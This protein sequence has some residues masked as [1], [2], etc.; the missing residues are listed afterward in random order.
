MRTWPANSSQGRPA[1]GVVSL[2]Q[3]R[4]GAGPLVAQHVLRVVQPRAGEPLRARHRAAAQ[5]P[6]GRRRRRDPEVIPDRLP[7]AFEIGH[8]PAPQVVVAVEVQAALAAEPA[9][10]RGQVR[11][12]HLFGAGCPQQVAVGYVGVLLSPA[13]AF[14]PEGNRASLPAVLTIF[15]YHFPMPR[16]RL[17]PSPVQALILRGHCHT[18]ALYGILPSAQSWWRPGRVSAGLGGAVP[19]AVGGAARARVAGWGRVV[20]QQQALRDCAQAMANYFHGSHCKPSWRKAGR[21]EG[22]RIV[23]LRPGQVRRLNRH[24][25]Q[26]SSPRRAGCGSLVSG[27][28]EARSFRVKLDRGRWHVAF[29]AVPAPIG[30]PVTAGGWRSRSARRC[31]RARCSPARA[32]GPPAAAQTAPARLARARRGSN[33]R[34][35]SSP[36]SRLRAREADARKDSAEKLSTDVRADST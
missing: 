33:R 29:A 27:V 9:G 15:R 16:Y 23:A 4:V 5:H 28:P 25:G 8:R 34:V 12:G 26:V 18:P 3:Q 10:E 2:V 14:R 1:R 20:V 22:F 7:E 35:R 17:M 31:P 21:D 13:A 30:G 36:R 19:P 32:C 6:G 11:L 24:W